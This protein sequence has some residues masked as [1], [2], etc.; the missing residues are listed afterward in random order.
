MKI[1]KEIYEY[2]KVQNF[3]PDGHEFNKA[4][5][6]FYKHNFL[7]TQKNEIILLL[8]CYAEKAK[9]GKTLRKKII[10]FMHNSTVQ[11]SSFH[12]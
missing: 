3:L 5:A 9:D 8:E 7:Q 12:A 4:Y 11:C 1:N 2:E 10:F 6:H